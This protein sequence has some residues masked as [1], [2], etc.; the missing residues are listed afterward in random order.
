MCLPVGSDC[1]RKATNSSLRL[2]LVERHQL[3]TVLVVLSKNESISNRG[4]TISVHGK[5]DVICLGSFHTILL[6][7][8]FDICQALFHFFLLANLKKFKKISGAFILYL[9]L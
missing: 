9:P 7:P 8:I 2:S 1:F 3:S 5:R 4:R 6:S